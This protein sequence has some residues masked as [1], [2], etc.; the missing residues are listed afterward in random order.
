MYTL[1]GEQI[2]SDAL[3]V[4]GAENIFADVAMPAPQVS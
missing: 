4:C 3:P 2:I 1:G